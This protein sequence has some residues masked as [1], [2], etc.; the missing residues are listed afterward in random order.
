MTQ[1]TH[2]D[3]T[4]A[5]VR[6]GARTP[7]GLDR[8]Y[9]LIELRRML[10]NPWTIGF[11]VVMPVSLYLL[12]GAGPDYGALPLAHGNVAGSILVNMGLYGA[13]VAVTF[14]VGALTGARLDPGAWAASFLLAWVAGTAMFAAFGLAV[15]YLFTGE[16]VL[17]V[18]GPLLTLFALFGGLF[19]PLDGLGDGIVGVASFMPM[20]GIR[21][22]AGAP[23]TGA[24]LDAA[25][26]ANA[27]IWFAVLAGVA[28][29]RFRRVGGRG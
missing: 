2:L 14:G 9:Q 5:L 23:V 4:T 11:S 21:L 1:T 26:L 27:L 20:Y 6:P 18:A 29:W 10:R 22:L 16:A 17:G 8:I 7:G 3:G 24:G 19:V 25:A 13:M 28:M 15:G 12:F